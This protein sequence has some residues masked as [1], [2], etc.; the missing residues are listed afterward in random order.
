MR[1]PERIANQTMAFGV[2]TGDQGEVVW[3]C[4]RGEGRRHVLWRYAG[5]DEAIECWRQTAVQEVC[6]E[7]VKR[8]EDGRGREDRG[9][10]AQVM[11]LV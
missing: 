9:S 10:V 2:Q 5:A 7:A 4:H 11:R 3:E 1:V 6:P 8:Y